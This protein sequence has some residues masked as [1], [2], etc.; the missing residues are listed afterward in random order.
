MTREKNETGEQVTAILTTPT[1]KKHIGNRP[2]LK[3][4]FTAIFGRK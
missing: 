4:I 2:L 1:G 3:R